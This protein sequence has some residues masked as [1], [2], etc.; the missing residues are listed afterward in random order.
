MVLPAYSVARATL[1]INFC[2]HVKKPKLEHPMFHIFTGD[3]RGEGEIWLTPCDGFRWDAEM[4]ER[5]RDFHGR[6]RVLA[7]EDFLVAKLGRVDRSSTDVDEVMQILFQNQGTLDW[8]Y[9]KKRATWAGVAAVLHEVVR[10]MG[11]PFV[12]HLFM[13]S[14]R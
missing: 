11:P 8:E 7:P 13:R 1:G 12:E 6:F 5:T 2:I 3:G 9:L 14:R 10:E 4:L